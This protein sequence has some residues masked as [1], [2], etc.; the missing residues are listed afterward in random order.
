[1]KNNDTNKHLSTIVPRGTP[2]K[3]DFTTEL[4]TKLPMLSQEAAENLLVHYQ[5]LKKWNKTHNLTRIISDAE[6]LNK[7]Y[8]DAL[9]PLMELE[10]PKSLADLGSGTGLPGFAA[11][12]LWPETKI[13]LVETV[14]KKCSFMRA[15]AAAQQ[16]E[17]VK[18]VKGRVEKIAP[19]N[20]DMLITRATFPWQSVPEFAAR[21]I[22]KGGKLLAYIGKEQPD[23]VLWNKVCV[24]QNLT[25]A[26]IQSYTLPG[27]EYSRHLGQA[28][29]K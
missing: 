13:I 27:T 5:I 16:V 10:A 3:K 22:R 21:H 7:H 15:V 1:M 24:E 2:E 8:L 18:I 20:V 29:K 25:E 6:A 12:A 14:A 26:K 19:L 11:A 17:H 9:L 28:A 23:P 4:C